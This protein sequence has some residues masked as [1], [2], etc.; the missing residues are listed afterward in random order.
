MSADDV[1][2]F[3]HVLGGFAAMAAAVISLALLVTTWRGDG[4]DA[5]AA[6]LPLTRPRDVLFVVGGALTLVFG[7]WLAVYVDGYELWDGWILAALLLWAV[8]AETGRRGGRADAQ[9]RN[10]TA[11]RHGGTDAATTPGGDALARGRRAML[12][13][14]VYAASVVAIL[15]LMI[16]KPGGA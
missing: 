3:L 7:I 12:L 16:F 11:L 15:A 5:A 6:L 2:L 4:S 9:I 10:A 1:L 8:A 13:H 14:L